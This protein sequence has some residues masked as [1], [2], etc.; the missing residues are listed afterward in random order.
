MHST[1]AWI[2]IFF[3]SILRA[4]Q[5]TLNIVDSP[6]LVFIPIAPCQFE[7]VLPNLSSFDQSTVSS[8]LRNLLKP[9]KSYI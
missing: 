4:L 9:T 6:I 2:I 3:F 7:K 1:S 8:S 5:N